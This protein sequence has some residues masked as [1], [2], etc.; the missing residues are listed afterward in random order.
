MANC[1][2]EDLPNCGGSGSKCCDNVGAKLKEIGPMVFGPRSALKECGLLD[3]VVIK[4][5]LGYNIVSILH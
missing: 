1:I 3:Q 2:Q 5:R 4:V